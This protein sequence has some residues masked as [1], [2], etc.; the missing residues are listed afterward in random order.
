MCLLSPDLK[1]SLIYGEEAPRFHFAVGIAEY[2][3]APGRQTGRKEAGAYLSESM[4]SCRGHMAFIIAPG[5]RR[6]FRELSIC[7]MDV[8]AH[9]K[10]TVLYPGL[11]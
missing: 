9:R 11:F 3:S 7:G 2:S 5:T 10:L 6:L 8:F 1:F 4:C